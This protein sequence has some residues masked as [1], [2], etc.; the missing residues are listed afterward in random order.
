MGLRNDAVSYGEGA[1]DQITNAEKNAVVDRDDLVLL[2]A[3]MNKTEFLDSLKNHASA[4]V[5]LSEI[6]NAM[7]MGNLLVTKEHEDALNVVNAIKEAGISDPVK[8]VAALKK[9]IE[10]NQKM[11][12]NAALDTAFGADA[13]GKNYLRQYAEEKIAIN[14]ADVPA[15]VEEVKKSPVALKLAADHADYLSEFN[16]TGKIDGANKDKKAGEPVVFK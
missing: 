1:M 3:N 13:E 6:A 10:D 7:G 15:A 8:E 16:K 5:T 12:R 4:G 2:G 11:V 14:C 9:T